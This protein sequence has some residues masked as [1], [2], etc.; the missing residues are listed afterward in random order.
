MI[1][2]GMKEVDFEAPAGLLA[3]I[4][5]AGEDKPRGHLQ[6]AV[7]AFRDRFREMHYCL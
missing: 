7:K 4:V 5:H 1:R 6:D 3:E 2:H